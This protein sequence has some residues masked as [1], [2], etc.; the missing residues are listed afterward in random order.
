MVMCDNCTPHRSLSWLYCVTYTTIHDCDEESPLWQGHE[1][2]SNAAFSAELYSVGDM[3]F[4]KEPNANQAKMP[5][6][7]L[8]FIQWEMALYCNI[9]ISHHNIM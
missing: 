3:C 8:S 2:A 1:M 5:P 9:I 7:Q 6:K 4:K